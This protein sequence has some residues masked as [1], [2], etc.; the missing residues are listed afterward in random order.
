MGRK[1]KITKEMVLQAAYEILD[2]EGIAAVGIKPIAARLGCSTQPVSWL[3]GSM[4]EL[5]K[6]LFLYSCERLYGGLDEKMQGRS[7][8]DAFFISGVWYISNA[9]DH[10]NVF[11]FTN[12][13]DP[14][15]TIGENPLGDKSIF[16][17][18][19]DELAV[20]MLAKEFKISKKKISAAVQNTVIY[21]HGLAC[22]MMWDNYRLPKEKACRMLFDVGVTMLKDIGVE[23]RKTWKDFAA[24]I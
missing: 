7:G 13:D 23:S 4:T 5:R 9:C 10:P 22:M 21:T 18:Q 11:R 20:E 17:E 24:L 12:V 16:A 3:F 1:A 19:M 15:I 2:E 6:A 8:L 14:M